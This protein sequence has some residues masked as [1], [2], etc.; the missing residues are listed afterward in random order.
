MAPTDCQASTVLGQPGACP[1]GEDSSYSAASGHRAMP[2]CTTWVSP[3]RKWSSSISTVD[4]ASAERGQSTPKITIKER[5][6][7][8]RIWRL[9][10]WRAKG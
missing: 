9:P 5:L 3:G 2:P 10:S 4:V 8:C 6:T 1:S 7:V